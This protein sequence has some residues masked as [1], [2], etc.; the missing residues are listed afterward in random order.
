MCDQTIPYERG[1]WV[2]SKVLNKVWWP[3]K[4][5]NLDDTPEDYRNYVAE[6][7]KIVAIVYFNGD[8]TH[9]LIINMSKI[10]LY[11][12]PNKMQF[13]ERGHALYKKQ[14]NGKIVIGNF[15][16]KNFI[17]DV[18]LAERE[19]GGDEN[20]FEEFENKSQ[21]VHP[22]I[23][24]RELFV[25]SKD[26]KKK[27]KSLLT[28]KTQSAFEKK[29][30]SINSSC[31]LMM[32]SGVYWC[33]IKKGCGYNSKR[34][35]NLKRHMKMHKEEDK[36]KLDAKLSKSNR[37][38]SGSSTR[39]AKTQFR[40]TRSK[41]AKT[42][43]LD[44]K[45]IKLQDELLKDWDE[46]DD[47]DESTDLSNA[48]EASTSN[49]IFDF[50]ED[51]SDESINTSINTSSDLRRHESTHSLLE[52]S[53]STL[54]QI[55]NLQNSFEDTKD[56]NTAASAIIDKKPI[57]DDNDSN[58]TNLILN[59]VEPTN[60]KSQKLNIN[61]DQKLSL[62]GT[63]INNEKVDS[64]KDSNFDSFLSNTPTPDWVKQDAWNTFE[65]SGLDKVKD[66]ITI[67]DQLWKKPLPN[68]L[69]PLISKEI[70]PLEKPLFAHKITPDGFP[71]NY[72]RCTMWI[73]KHQ[74]VTKST[75][76]E[77]LQMPFF[78]EIQQKVSAGNI[79]DLFITIPGCKIVPKL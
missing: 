18:L 68:V 6:K 61:R 35:E 12:C 53:D 69:A 66:F 47:L 65:H 75:D 38:V 23:N 36:R 62:T 44:T 55:N 29:K 41:N 54:Y 56:E 74:S 3:G 64:T 72:M 50:D 20:I 51:D 28:S 15:N 21:V 46:D 22:H 57:S 58:G 40:T 60:S 27:R 10:M 34:F 4:V 7:K 76:E 17:A 48:N 79:D 49:Q 59:N 45:K 1:T 67:D 78:Q 9:D 77:L 25:S 73:P 30:R 31:K 24:V 16:M 14:M 26:L 32:E 11:N 19:T 42:K 33:H 52:N 70:M 8:K 39:S 13:I 37:S 63:S 2:W 5:V 43:K 71:S